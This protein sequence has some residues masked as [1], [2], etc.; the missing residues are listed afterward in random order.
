MSLLSE[1]GF[2]GCAGWTGW[3]T[4]DAPAAAVT[5]CGAR[6]FVSHGAKV[7]KTLMSIARRRNKEKRSVRTLMALMSE[8][9][10]SG[11]SG[12]PGWGTSDAPV[13]SAMV[14]CGD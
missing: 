9:G 10:F 5:V 14:R 4:F 3:G 13:A 12:W 6:A 2:S 1:A 11:F 7:W 8:A